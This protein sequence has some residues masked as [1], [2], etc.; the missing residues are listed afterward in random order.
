MVSTFLTCHLLSFKKG[1]KGIL[2][3]HTYFPFILTFRP[4]R[5]PPANNTRLPNPPSFIKKYVTFYTYNSIIV[6]I[7]VVHD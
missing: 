3:N 4:N 6:N 5:Y 1:S 2:I 7:K